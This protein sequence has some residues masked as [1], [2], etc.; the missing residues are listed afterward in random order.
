[1]RVCLGYHQQHWWLL[2]PQD[3]SGPENE[4]TLE[5]APWNLFTL[6]SVSL[7]A[8]AEW[9]VPPC[10]E[11]HSLILIQLCVFVFVHA[12][13]LPL[14]SIRHVC[15]GPLHWPPLC[16][17]CSVCT[18]P[19]NWFFAVPRRVA[20]YSSEGP[21]AHP[22]SHPESP[23]TSLSAA[24]KLFPPNTASQTSYSLL[25]G[26]CSS[27]HHMLLTW[28]LVLISGQASSLHRSSLTT[29]PTRAPVCSIDQV[30]YSTVFWPLDRVTHH[31]QH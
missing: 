11:S 23:V 21:T 4:A 1:M 20:G 25:H 7:A 22:H 9:G 24:P 5:P 10:Q 19:L 13:S 18:G 17:T 14:C 15:T 27:D 12:A 6:P 3:L 2:G 8:E 28:V 29:L 31:Q 26:F 16:S 30:G